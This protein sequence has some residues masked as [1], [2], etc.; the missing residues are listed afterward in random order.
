MS[1]LNQQLFCQRIKALFPDYFRH[2]SVL[3]IGGADINGSVRYLFKNCCYRVVDLWK[4]PGVDYV[5]KVADL[6]RFQYGT[7]CCL[8]VAEHD[9]EYPLTIME[10]I[11]RLRLGG[12][13][14]FTCASEGRPEHG[15]KATS[16][17]DSPFTTNY[18]KNL[19][20]ADI[21][22]INGFNEVWEW[23][24]FE[25]KDQDLRFYGFKKDPEWPTIVLFNP[26]KWR[27]IRSYLAY[28]FLRRKMD[29]K[30]VIKKGPTSS[31]IYKALISS[32]KK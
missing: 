14:L 11:K 28:W 13:F 3:D 30:N 1:H 22:A 6:T 17:Q 5:G 7:V 23:C 24:W 12:L 25:Q 16:P 32:L 31:E 21:R 10:G 29:V 18:Y 8:E 4:G 2:C 20:E 26:S 19:M 9:Q 15:T 27:F